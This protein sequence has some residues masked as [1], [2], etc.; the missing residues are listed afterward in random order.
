MLQNGDAI[1]REQDIIIIM[2]EAVEEHK[3]DC[4]VL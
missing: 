3:R 1:E 4:I 2:S